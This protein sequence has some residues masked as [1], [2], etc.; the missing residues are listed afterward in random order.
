MKK[1]NVIGPFEKVSFPVFGLF[2]VV[3]KIDTGAYSGAVHATEIEEINLPTGESA[4]AFR[5]FGKGPKVLVNSF[6]QSLVRSSNGQSAM[7][8]IIPTTLEIQNVQ[9]QIKISLAD[10]SMMKNGVLIGQRFLKSHGFIVDVTRG[11]KYGGLE[12]EQK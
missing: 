2:D 4:V 7:R 6:E 8:Y 10:R 5:P 11:S 1:L 9:Y 12:K 3:A